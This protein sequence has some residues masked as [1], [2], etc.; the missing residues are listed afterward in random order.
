[1]AGRMA[2][3]LAPQVKVILE[4][5]GAVWSVKDSGSEVSNDAA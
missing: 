3:T 4:K 1:M 2:T 5:Q